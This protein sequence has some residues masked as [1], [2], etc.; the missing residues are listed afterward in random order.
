MG[1]KMNH[2][3]LPVRV[4][5]F[6][7]PV[8]GLMNLNFL[9]AWI[10]NSYGG[11]G[12]NRPIVDF[13]NFSCSNTNFRNSAFKYHNRYSNIRYLR[14]KL[15]TRQRCSTNE[16]DSFHEWGWKLIKRRFWLYFEE[17]FIDSRHYENIYIEAVLGISSPLNR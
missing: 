12:E 14:K 5:I 6:S 3:P 11:D 2:L 7:L 13:N 10:G 9:L 15:D 1:V 17:T 16:S 4:T 8:L